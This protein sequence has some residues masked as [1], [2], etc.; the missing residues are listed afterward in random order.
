MPKV[1]ICD[2]N[3]NFGSRF[4]F[5]IKAGKA[6]VELTGLLRA[7]VFRTTSITTL[8]CLPIIVVI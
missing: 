2:T 4:C 3:Y 8:D 5:L 1:Q 6:R 7:V